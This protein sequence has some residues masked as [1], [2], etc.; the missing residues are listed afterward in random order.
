MRRAGGL[1]RR[2][3]I[4]GAIAMPVLGHVEAGRADAEGISNLHD[5]ERRLNRLIQ[6]S[7]RLAGEVRRLRKLCA[8][9]CAERGISAFLDDWRRNPEFDAVHREQ[10]YDAAW[11]RWSAT[12]VETMDLSELIRKTPATS[13]AGMA[14]KY[15]ALLWELYHDQMADAADPEHLRLLK[16]FGRE[17]DGVS[18]MASR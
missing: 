2:D 18:A 6:R 15:R 12:I 7:R 11:Q 17:L 16:A 10:G 3:V 14:V 9:I 1:T 5:L 13:A 4:A 8:E